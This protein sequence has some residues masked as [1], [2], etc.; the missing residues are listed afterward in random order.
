MEDIDQRMEKPDPS[1][2]RKKT[3][4]EKDLTVTFAEGL[5]FRKTPKADVTEGINNKI[6]IINTVILSIMT[7]ESLAW[8]QSKR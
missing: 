6:T 7:Y 1:R 8:G 2:Q 3:P 5:S 4:E